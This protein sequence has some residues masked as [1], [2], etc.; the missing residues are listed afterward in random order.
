MSISYKYTFTNKILTAAHKKSRNNYNEIILS[1]ICGCF[2]CQKIFT[3]DKVVHWIKE[4]DGQSTAMCDC[5][6]D[7][8][9]GS[10]SRYPINKTFLSDMHHLWFLA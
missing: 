1:K 9:V 7:A 2:C 8:V 6:I 10:K 3:P 4:K 5:G